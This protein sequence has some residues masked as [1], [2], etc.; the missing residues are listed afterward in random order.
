MQKMINN[1]KRTILSSDVTID[2]L[3]IDLISE[4]INSKAIGDELNEI[5]RLIVV[6]DNKIYLKIK[7][8]KNA[9]GHIEINI[10]SRYDIAQILKNIGFEHNRIRDEE[11]IMHRVWIIL[12]SK[13]EIFISEQDN[14]LEINTIFNS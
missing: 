3:I 4:Q 10:L 11:G 7:I 13:F 12:V 9:M 8:I 6:K 2:G 14:I 5:D 1:A